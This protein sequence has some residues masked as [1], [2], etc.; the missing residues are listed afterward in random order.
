MRVKLSSVISDLFGV[1]GLRILHAL[2]EGETD[3]K[4]LAALGNNCLK[5]TEEQFADALNGCP[6]PLHR[7]MLQLDLQRLELLDKQIAALNLLI[8]QALKPHQDAVLRLAEVAGFGVDSAQQVIA[9]TGVEASTFDSAAPLS[10]WVGTC[11]GRDES[12]EENHSSRSPK[13]NRYMRR[14]LTETAHAAVKTKGSYFQV[15]FRRLLL[16]LGFKSAIW[17]IA[18]RLCRLV[19]KIL[20]EKVAY[21]EYGADR[22]PK[23]KKQR[24]QTLA[25]SLRKLGYKVEIT[26]L[27]LTT[28]EG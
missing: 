11:P 7:E 24:A 18:H 19:G 16:R 20:H 23:A 1:S 12:A 22:D 27:R 14:V 8:A 21:I 2:A 9:E 13:G 26:P 28:A 4:K 25:R 15:L 3:A 6:L 5:C 10:A 17:A